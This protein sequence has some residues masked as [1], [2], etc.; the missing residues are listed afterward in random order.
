MLIYSLP[1]FIK[2]RVNVRH[3][4]I[5]DVSRLNAVRSLDSWGGASFRLVLGASPVAKV[6]EATSLWQ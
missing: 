3:A 1:H 2:E 5:H 4:Q 6:T